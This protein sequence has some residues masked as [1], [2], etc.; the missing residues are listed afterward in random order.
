MR[1]AIKA[2]A[3]VEA[4]RH[5]LGKFVSI[6]LAAGKGTRMKSHLP[7]VLHPL[8]GLPMLEHVVRSAEAA[9][10]THSIVVLNSDTKLFAPYAAKNPQLGFAIQQEQKGTA[11]AVASAGILLEGVKMPKYANAKIHS[12]AKVSKDESDLVLICTGDT[13][14]IAP[15]TLRQFVEE[16]VRAKAPL[17]VIGI[18]VPD[19]TGYG[20]LVPG[21]KGDLKCVIEE[22][23]TTAAQK[24]IKLINSGIVFCHRRLLFDLLGE[25]DKKNS[26]NEFYLTS[27]FSLAA[28]KKIKTHVFVAPDWREFMGVNDRVQL[29]AAE[30]YLLERKRMSLQRSGV[31]IAMP[32]TVFIDQD[33]VVGADTVIGHGVSLTNGT[34]IG[35]GCA[36]APHARLSDVVVEDGAVIGAG[37]TLEN[38]KIKRAQRVEPNT[39][40]VG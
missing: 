5:P 26:Q 1:A 19:P 18:R 30:A 14:C 23:D 9:G 2:G 33:V 21:A 6:I 34:R 20:R 36:V 37:A 40:R 4:S 39:V 25:V 11:D 24:E 13:P 10:S 32:E 38:T 28:G 22:R 8:I 16:C 29:A 35:E 17:G 15:E 31:T 27:L 12:G 3:K 7:K